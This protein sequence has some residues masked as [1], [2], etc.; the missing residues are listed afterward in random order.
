M[1]HRTGE[2]ALVE[3]IE[4]REAGI[5]VQSGWASR[6]GRGHRNRANVVRVQAVDGLHAGSD[7][8]ATMLRDYNFAVSQILLPAGFT[9]VTDTWALLKPAAREVRHAV[10][11]VEQHIPIEL[12][13]D[14]WDETALHAVVHDL[15]G[16]PVGTGRLLPPAF[17]PAAPHTGHIGRMAVVAPM[18]R[19]GIGGAIL[20]ALMAAAPALG[21]HD[22]VLHAQSYVARFYER[23]G[24]T[25]E[26]EEF[27]EAGIPHRTMRGTP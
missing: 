5:P 9:L 19:A 1:A 13:W 12:E 20:Q 18:R 16:A 14:E 25:V 8:R 22:I 6:V 17:D 4:G 27:M 21:Y 11:V 3:K 7:A 2:H 26:G 15:N 23:Y 24:F 10:F